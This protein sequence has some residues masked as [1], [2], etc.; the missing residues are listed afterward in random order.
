M[1]KGD[2]YFAN[3]DPSIGSETKKKRPVLIVSNNSQNTY[4]DRVIIAPIT[5]KAS[6]V[7]PFETSISCNKIHGKVM[8]DQ[9]RTLDKQRLS[10]FQG[11]VSQTIITQVEKALKVVLD[12]T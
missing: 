1:R 5:S 10:D 11:H 2:I 6:K 9:I 4:S 8:C 12:L 3:L 7:Y